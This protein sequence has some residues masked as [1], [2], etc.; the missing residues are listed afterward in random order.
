[1]TWAAQ[2][3]HVMAKD[4]RQAR[5]LLFAYLGLVLISWARALAWS[6]TPRGVLDISMYL[7]VLAG[8]FVAGSVVQAD[9]PIRS[10][11]FWGSRPL[12][13]AA[14][15]TAKA[16]LALLI[17]VTVP[18]LAQ[19]HALVASGVSGGALLGMLTRSVWMYAL[20][21]LIAMVLA[22]VTQDIR[23]FIV[24]LVILPAG[25]AVVSFSAS[26]GWARRVRWN[27]SAMETIG[28]A[29]LVVVG[30]GAAVGVLVVLYR[31]RTLHRVVKVAAAAGVA[32][33]FLTLLGTP[34]RRRSER[35]LATI[36]G[37]FGMTVAADY[38]G[39]ILPELRL[40][41]VDA[42]KSDRLV[43]IDSGSVV[44]RLRDGTITT[45]PLRG[46]HLQL[47]TARL[48][49]DPRI[50]WRGAIPGEGRGAGSFGLFLT[51][52]QR[53]AL[54]VGIASASIEGFAFVAE[55]RVAFTLPFQAAASERRD[56][57]GV[58]IMTVSPT[59]EDSLAIVM[60][61]TITRS[62]SPDVDALLLFG[63]W[64]TPRYA[65]V[66]DTR[67]EAVLLG[68]GYGG[69]SEALVLP[70]AWRYSGPTQLRATQAGLVELP[71]DWYRGARLVVIDWAIVGR[72]PFHSPATV[73]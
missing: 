49:I 32:C 29:A 28:P 55:P 50:R 68:G 71:A 22:A 43:V 17:V 35:Q 60:Q 9:S 51:R 24:A 21:L 19:L 53:E 14:V 46:A 64:D 37:D 15:L 59:T 26:F 65:L 27:G 7:V 45:V 13:P 1:M 54:R 12:H 67:G 20:W 5:W 39:S 62:G 30:V 73:R 6:D 31:T 33:M 42:R 47:E 57:K 16:S 66:N 10:D 23:S 25:L 56:G 2:V 34:T 18:L 48:P 44:L 41:I 4:V 40:H 11:A 3:R 36:S 38:A 52:E 63:P 58:R 72:A 8:L 61:S 70:G 69:T